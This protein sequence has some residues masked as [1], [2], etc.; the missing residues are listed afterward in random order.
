MKPAALTVVGLVTL[1]TA[2]IG[3][4]AENLE[5][6]P[7]WLVPVRMS[8]GAQIRSFS[9]E[10]ALS[11]SGD[12]V[13]G[14]LGPSGDGSAEVSSRPA[15]GRWLPTVSEPGG[16]PSVAIDAAGNVFVAWFEPKDEGNS[17]G[18][19]NARVLSPKGT[20]G[21]ISQ[22][23]TAADGSINNN[24]VRVGTDVQGPA[25]EDRCHQGSGEAEQH[26]ATDRGSL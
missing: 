4:P 13:A 8:V 1:V 26:D 24:T 6:S 12:A 14:W 20:R 22:L 17:N 9:G 3:E 10:V 11:E 25:G 15:G 2:G 7:T 5:S 19:V 23:S 16:S 21:T 18:I